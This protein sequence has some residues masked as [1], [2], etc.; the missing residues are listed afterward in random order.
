MTPVII[1]G[2][3][4]VLHPA[5]GRHG[6]VI[7]GSLG[8]EALNIHRS[9]VF[10][11]ERF[12]T[13]GFPTLRVHYYGTADSAGDDDEP[14]RFEAWIDSIVRAARWLRQEYGVTRVSLCG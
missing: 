5:Q 10:L 2:T 3:Y 4:C 9:L 6:V 14:A 12:A 11:G 1:H 8:D 13:A 7:C